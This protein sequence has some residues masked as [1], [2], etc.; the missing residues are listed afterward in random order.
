M[1][2]RKMAAYKLSRGGMTNNKNKNNSIHPLF[3][4]N[5]S[6]TT[7]LTEKK[8]IAVITRSSYGPV[9]KNPPAN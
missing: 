9:I 8:K 1:W 5:H 4:N 2:Y 7:K 3:E 6:T